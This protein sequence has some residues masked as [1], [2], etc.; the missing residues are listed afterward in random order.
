[1]L[2]TTWEYFLVSSDSIE[3]KSADDLFTQLVHMYYDH[4]FLS[5]WNTLMTRR[6]HNA[7]WFLKRH[8]KQMRKGLLQSV[9]DFTT[10]IFP[11]IVRNLRCRDYFINGYLIV[12]MYLWN[13]KKSYWTARTYY[14]EY[15][16]HWHT[17]FQT[18]NL[19]ISRRDSIFGTHT[20]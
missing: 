19:C 16:I 4:T 13:W 1:M 3:N 11:Q 6:A 5:M 17:I 8:D 7:L 15:Q 9:A 18:S 14:A 12:Y 2:I 20:L 10:R